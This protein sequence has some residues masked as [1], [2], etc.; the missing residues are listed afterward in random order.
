MTIVLPGELTPVTVESLVRAG[1]DPARVLRTVRDALVEDLWLG[2]DVT[3]ESVVTESAEAVADVVPRATGTLAGV[4]VAAAVLDVLGGGSLRLTPLAADGDRVVPEQVVLSVEGSVRALLTAER[5]LLN[6]L[7]RLSGV[8]TATRAWVDVVAGTGA[9]IR[10]TRKTTPGLRAL[11]KY[12]VRCGGGVNHRLALGDE[13]LIK[14]NHVAAAGGVS[15][16]LAAVR[17]ASPDV[18]V[19][20]ECDTVEQVREA[21]AAG[22]PLLLLDNMTLEEMRQAVA[23]ARPAGVRLEASGGLT[24][25]RARAVAELGVD[26]LAVGA[27]THSAPAL[28]LGLDLRG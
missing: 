16:A 27:L 26:Y 25:D 3:T 6:L 10:D 19:E 1:L 11:E 8:A 14:D 23:L 13:A 2:P 24:L 18:P 15:A 9:A 4:P 28:D 17:A 5:T 22:A 21:V 7:G 12:A 20:V